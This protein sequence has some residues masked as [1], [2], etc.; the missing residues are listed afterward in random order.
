MIQVKPLMVLIAAAFCGFA[1]Y[2]GSSVA[3]SGDGS[4]TLVVELNNNRPKCPLGRTQTA[5]NVGGNPLLSN[6]GRVYG[7]LSR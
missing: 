4:M 3:Q 6:F 2:V 7:C 5:L 1:G